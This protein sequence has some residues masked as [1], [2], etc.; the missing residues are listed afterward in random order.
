M[1]RYPGRA[2]EGRT[3]EEGRVRRSAR[4]RVEPF[5][6][7]ELLKAANERAATRG[8]VITLCAGQPSTAAPRAAREAAARALADGAVLGYT[9][10]VGIAPLREAIAGYCAD[11]YGVSVDPDQVVVTT[12]SS[13]AF[14]ALFLAAFD[15]GDTVVMARPGYPAYRNTLG[16]LG[17][18]VVE[19]DCGASVRF[20]PTVA[21]LEEVT[22]DLGSPPAGLIVASPANPTGTVIDASELAAI[23]RWCE[24]HGTLLISDEI[25]HGV[26]YGCSVAS[27]WETSRSS[28]LVGSMSKYFS[29][30]GWRVGWLVLPRPLVR[31]VE[32]LLGNLNICAPAICQVAAVAAFSP[33]AAEE[34]RGHVARYAVNRDLLLR[35]APELGITRMAPPDGAFYL[36]ADV[37]HLTDVSM[38][39]TGRVL[40]D[41]GVALTPGADFDTARGHR[42]VRVSFAGGTDEIDEAISRLAAYV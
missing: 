13:A 11:S 33:E 9:D 32:L 30:T 27:A 42:Y 41:T 26:T 38:A 10:A 3:S 34:L 14:T 15:V 7:M 28:V 18:S 5:H 24:A 21:L 25:Y 29:M 31:P 2:G 39:W 40:A 23:A 12:G 6:V 37:S 4:G 1:T 17:C 20:Q 16:A 8:D 22:A 35:R 36:Y 19:V